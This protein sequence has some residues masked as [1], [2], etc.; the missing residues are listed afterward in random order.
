MF[1]QDLNIIPLQ[2]GSE[3][4]HEYRKTRIGASDCPCIM[5]VGF[6]TPLQLWKIKLGL[7]KEQVTEHMQRGLDLEP[8]ARE[9]FMKKL[10]LYVYPCVV[11]SKEL[12]WQ[13]ASLDGLSHDGKTAVEI[14]CPGEKDH[15][16]ALQGLIPE[17]YFPQLQHQ[18]LVLNLEFMY[19]FS[20]SEKSSACVKVYADKE[21]QRE[22]L[23]KEQDFYKRLI[24]F[25]QPELTDRDYIQKTDHDFLYHVH[26]Y[27]K[28]LT[29]EKQI[30]QLKESHRNA[31]IHLANKQNVEGGGIRVHQTTRKGLVDYNAIPELI[32]V[33]LEKYR[34][35]NIESVRITEVGL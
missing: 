25:E 24:T 30:E 11:E 34:R 12:P 7:V 15:N 20:F 4:W 14:K 31:I 18:L 29:Q 19:Y 6:K 26:E 3:S 8:I 5:G 28:L 35:P 1:A 23:K 10:D 13:F 33:D 2:Q 9:S 27:R 32:G 22:L 16:L 21:Y 17:K